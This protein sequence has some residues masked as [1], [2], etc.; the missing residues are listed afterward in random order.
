[1]LLFLVV[2]S[3]L[4]YALMRVAEWNEALGRQL[5]L[6]R[7]RFVSVEM[8]LL[9]LLAVL[10]KA[11]R[12]RSFGF[13]LRFGASAFRARR[14]PWL[15]LK[16]TIAWLREASGPLALMFLWIGFVLGLAFWAFR[17]GIAPSRLLVVALGVTAVV[18][19]TSVI[20]SALTRFV[21]SRWIFPRGSFTPE[22][23][24][25]RMVTLTWLPR[26]QRD[27]LRRT[28]AESL[29]LDE[30]SYLEV[31]REIEPTIQSEPAL[32]TY[33]DQRDQI[34]QALRQERQG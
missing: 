5:G 32:S 11:S 4:G 29:G 18:L 2:S 12:E 28:A 7:R 15:A 23:W 6:S 24:V 21:F 13:V 30:K 1:M 14:K 20:H 16:K 25:G 33:W 8:I 22:A 3:S 19:L 10:Y 17:R 9:V 34:E 27:F 31:L 26:R